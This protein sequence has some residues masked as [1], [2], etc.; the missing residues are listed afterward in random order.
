MKPKFTRKEAMDKA[1]ENKVRLYQEREKKLELMLKKAFEKEDFVELLSDVE[2]RIENYVELGLGEISLSSKYSGD[3]KSEVA[4]FY[5]DA[6]Y[7]V[8]VH[9]EN[10]RIFWV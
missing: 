8:F 5:R 3:Y 10:I 1:C 9:V 4:K 7:E 6:G 2:I